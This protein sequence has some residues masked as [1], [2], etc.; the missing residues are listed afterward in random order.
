MIWLGSQSF[1][2]IFKNAFNLAFLF[3]FKIQHFWIG[4]YVLWTGSWLDCQKPRG[5]FALVHSS[6][7]GDFDLVL[8]FHAPVHKLSIIFK[9]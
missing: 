7:S 5:I 3:P 9:F 6:I 8:I 2:K 1:Q 4:A